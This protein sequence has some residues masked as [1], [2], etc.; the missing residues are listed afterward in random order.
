MTNTSVEVTQVR[1]L[2][3]QSMAYLGRQLGHGPLLWQKNQFWPVV[4]LEIYS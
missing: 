2:K 3:V 4:F 1:T